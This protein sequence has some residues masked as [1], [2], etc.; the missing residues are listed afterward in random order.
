MKKESQLFQNAYGR[1]VKWYNE[2]L[3]KLSSFVVL[4]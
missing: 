1:L 2:L 4:S 3:F